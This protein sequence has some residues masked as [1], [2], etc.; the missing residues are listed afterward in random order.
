MYAVG[1]IG[2]GTAGRLSVSEP[3]GFLFFFPPY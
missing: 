3:G 2:S 1:L